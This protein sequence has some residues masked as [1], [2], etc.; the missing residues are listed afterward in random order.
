MKS[1]PHI[2][3]IASAV[4]LVVAVILSIIGDKIF[5]ATAN[6]WLDLAWVLAVF[7]IATEMVWVSKEKS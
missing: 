7:S 6:G 1:L 4:A 2:S 5:I 3:L